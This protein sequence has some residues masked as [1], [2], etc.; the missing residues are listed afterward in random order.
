MVSIVAV[1]AIIVLRVEVRNDL[2]SLL[3]SGQSPGHQ[4]IVSQ[5]RDGPAARI[6]LVGLEG[7]PP[8]VLAATSSGLA[9][10]LQR[11]RHIAS[12]MNGPATVS[13]ADEQAVFANRYLL[14]RAADRPRYEVAD[15]RAAFE[16]SLQRLLSSFGVLESRF[17]AADPTGA[18]AKIL[19]RWGPTTSLSVRHGVWFSSSG[20]RALLIVRT[21]DP[22]FDLDRHGAAIAEIRASFDALASP[23]RLILSGPG[24]FAVASRDVIQ[25]DVW[26]LSILG[27]LGVVVI[28][29]FAF[30]TARPVLL[31]IL[32]L[33]TAMVAGAGAVALVYGYVHGIT[34]AF[35]ATLTGVVADYPVHLISHRKPGESSHRLLARLWPPLRLGIV[36]TTIGYCV[37]MFSDVPGLA[38]L[39]LFSAAGLLAAGATT[40]WVLPGLLTASAVNEPSAYRWMA[41]CSALLAR[42]R[43]AVLALVIFAGFYLIASAGNIWQDDLAALSPVPEDAKHADR[44]LRADLGVADPRQLVAVIGKD[45]QDALEACERI[46][47]VLAT[48]ITDGMLRGF[49]APCAY[50][51]S[52]RTQRAHQASIPDEPILRRRVALASAG[53]PFK[54]DVFEPFIRDLVASKKRSPLGLDDLTDTTLGLKVSSLLA[55]RQAGWTAMLPLQDLKDSVGLAARVEQAHDGQ[56]LFLDLK[57]ESEELLRGYRVRAVAL[58]SLGFGSIAL[59]LWL[60]LR[61]FRLVLRIMLPVAAALILTCALLFVFG[62]ALSL[63]HLVSLILV[64]GLGLDY[65][66][67]FNLPRASKTEQRQSVRAVFL[68]SVTTVMVFALLAFSRVP[69]LAAIG[70]TVAL[71][72]ALCF[73]M[74]IIFAPAFGVAAR[75]SKLVQPA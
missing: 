33:A 39:G 45:A 55:P 30:R 63:F 36:T 57:R 2:S 58:W 25:N 20:D 7:A 40:R 14:A 53:L 10:R 31:S 1:G 59:V 70:S 52:I 38:Q 8:E 47:P 56:F 37:M 19:A 74:A 60:G 11:S 69:V 68:C 5:V 18:M 66:L 6:V 16:T 44:L 64:I 34:L 13:D 62:H 35:G 48:A 72:S 73:L 24:I 43:L 4:L 23:A 27:S 71:G 28:L 50:L 46:L 32:L 26:R 75:S 54:R 22:A 29:V 15:L 41:R 61:S 49:E 3:P 51:P 12:V 9:Q 67:F 21:N 17:I 65:L 42:L